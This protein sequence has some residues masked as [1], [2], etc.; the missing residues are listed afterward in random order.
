MI[1]KRTIKKREK[2]YACLIICIIMTYLICATRNYLLETTIFATDP[3]TKFLIQLYP[4][5]PIAKI[6]I[7]YNN[8]FCHFPKSQIVSNITLA[9][10]T[11]QLNHTLELLRLGRRYVNTSTELLIYKKSFIS[12]YSLYHLRD[13]Y[14]CQ[15]NSFC[16]NTSTKYT[17][18]TF[19][20]KA[21]NIST[22]YRSYEHLLAISQRY[23]FYGDVQLGTIHRLIMVPRDIIEKSVILLQ[24]DAQIRQL[25]EILEV[26]GVN[27]SLESIH[28]YE[29]VYARNLYTILPIWYDGDGEV[30]PNGL[31]HA[32][33]FPFM[34]EYA[35]MVRNY[36][37]VSNVVPFQYAVMNR[38]LGANR[39][40]KNI[41]KVVKAL[42]K[43]HPKKVFELVPSLYPTLGDTVRAAV[44]RKWVW[45]TVGSNVMNLIYM[46]P[47]TA[48]CLLM[49]DVYDPQSFGVLSSRGIWVVCYYDPR[50]N[51][52]RKKPIVVDVNFTSY[53]VNRSFYMLENQRHAPVPNMTESQ[54]KADAKDS[55][56]Y[57]IKKFFIRKF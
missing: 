55:I 18:D 23:H 45:C 14:Y 29:Y 5:I 39:H 44:I 52:F 33:S 26:M 9:F 48:V 53:Q 41:D 19:G 32:F 34:W 46:V 54:I 40:I 27:S 7:T 42:S 38:P 47:N 36:F 3:Y 2:Q 10:G 15:Q 57:N 56:S 24:N 50:W 11:K 21:D 31:H 51:H 25:V 6:N 43:Q 28:P 37:N 1:N 22:V 30:F 8:T 16:S 49:F 12:N 13:V 35:E 17:I 20:P 4:V